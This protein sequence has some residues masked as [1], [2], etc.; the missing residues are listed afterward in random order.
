[1]NIKAIT[2][3]YIPYRIYIKRQ[4]QNIHP[5]KTTGLKPKCLI[6]NDLK[7]DHHI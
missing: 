5:N 2:L 7:H 6:D 4:P 3:I 1:M